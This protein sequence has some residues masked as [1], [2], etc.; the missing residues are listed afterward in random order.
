MPKKKRAKKKTKKR[1]KKF[2]FKLPAI[3]AIRFPKLIP[4]KVKQAD[5]IVGIPSYN[6]ADSIGFVVEQVDKGLQKYFPKHS[7]VII[8]VD[9]SSLDGTK[10]VFL[11][12]RTETPK[13]YISTP[14]GVR[15]K[16]NNFHNLFRQAE[17]L[18]AKAVMVVDADLKSIKP[19][20]VRSLT[21]P[22]FRG[23]DFVTPV[24]ARNEYDG[25]IT[26]HLIYPLIYGLL[27][28]D[29]RQPIAGDFAFSPK[30]A[31]HWLDQ[32][33]DRTTKQYGIDVFMTLNAVFGNFKIGQVNLEAKVHKPS[34]PKLGPMFTQVAKTLFKGIA[35]NKDKCTKVKKITRPSTL[36][37]TKSSKVPGLSID[38]K[39]MKQTALYLFEINRDFLQRTLT[40]DVYEEVSEMYQKQIIK[41]PAE[42]WCKI[43]YDALHTYESTHREFSLVD[44][45]FPLYLGRM[46]T[47][48][49][50]TLDLSSAKS[51]AEI[52]AQA[53]VFY[54]NR[55][56]LL[57]KYKKHA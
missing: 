12:S 54:E 34:A 41:I 8:N 7:K 17:K 49:R 21:K 27:G 37:K 50:E 22:I 23:Y 24:Y 10:Q 48:I 53:K 46:I 52:V 5:I 28:Q 30:L 40:N 36:G 39:S 3:P 35:L 31:K 15:G 45:I 14:P 13:L 4:D 6:E 26:N 19:T 11:G 32:K 57:S 2:G 42:L 55:D 1:A 44:A 38:Y 20:W 33:W 43:L 29:I 51:E 25:T 56:Y 16:G 9:N 18:K 47:F